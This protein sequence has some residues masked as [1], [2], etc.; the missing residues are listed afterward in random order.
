M[1]LYNQL[2]IGF[3]YYVAALIKMVQIIKKTDQTRIIL[4]LE[5][6]GVPYENILSSLPPFQYG[7]IFPVISLL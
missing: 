7:I 3:N 2:V 6:T 4:N 5:V 1:L